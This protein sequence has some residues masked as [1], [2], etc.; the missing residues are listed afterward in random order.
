MSTRDFRVDRRN[1][2]ERRRSLL[3][4]IFRPSVTDLAQFNL[5]VPRGRIHGRCRVI[6]AVGLIVVIF[7][8]GQAES[9]MGVE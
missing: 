7:F 4:C 1:L 3:F 8:V 9:L 2:L 5:D 6:L